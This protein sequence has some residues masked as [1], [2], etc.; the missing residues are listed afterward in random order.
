MAARSRLNLCHTHSHSLICSYFQQTI[1]T[2]CVLLEKPM[3]LQR[4]TLYYISK[5]QVARNLSEFIKKVTPPSAN[6]N[7]NNILKFSR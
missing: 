1:L 4:Y 2:R 3:K 5:T 7:P 6:N